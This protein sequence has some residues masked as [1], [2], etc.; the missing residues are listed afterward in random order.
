VRGESF[1]SKLPVVPLGETQIGDYGRICPGSDLSETSLE[2]TLTG[3]FGKE[4]LK[5]IRGA[6]SGSCSGPLAQ[7]SVLLTLPRWEGKK[8]YPAKWHEKWAQCSGRR[9]EAVGKIG[10]RTSKPA[11]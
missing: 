3:T 8:A 7:V 2:T 4:L 11:D 1:V 6:L 5:R 10:A 9:L